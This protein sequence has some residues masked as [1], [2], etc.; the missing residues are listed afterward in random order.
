MIGAGRSGD[1][2]TY[3][4][5]LPTV[6]NSLGKESFN[7]ALTSLSAGAAFSWLHCRLDTYYIHKTF[8]RLATRVV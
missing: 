2:K 3:A 5:A 7:L 4:S 6:E 1:W 8:F